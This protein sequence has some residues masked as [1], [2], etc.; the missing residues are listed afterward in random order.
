MGWKMR[1]I[2][3]IAVLAGSSSADC[4]IELVNFRACEFSD[5]AAGGVRASTGYFYK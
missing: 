1:G 2:L 5:T 3:N 4:E